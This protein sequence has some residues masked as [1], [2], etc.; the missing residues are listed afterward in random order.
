MLRFFFLSAGKCGLFFDEY[1]AF[2]SPEGSD[3]TDN[4]LVVLLARR[5]PFPPVTSS[6]SASTT[7]SCIVAPRGLLGFLGVTQISVE[8]PN[9]R[10]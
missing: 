7:S 2:C 5:S 4:R 10:T 8:P 3:V 6:V 9:E 1:C